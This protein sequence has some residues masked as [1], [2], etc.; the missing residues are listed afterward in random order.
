MRFSFGTRRICQ[1][2]NQGEAEYSCKQQSS[3]LGYHSWWQCSSRKW[4]TNVRWH[5]KLAQLLQWEEW[6]K[7][8]FI[9]RINVQLGFCNVSRQELQ[10]NQRIGWYVSTWLYPW[11]IHEWK[12]ASQTKSEFSKNA[13][14]DSY[15]QR[16]AWRNNFSKIHKTLEGFR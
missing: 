16:S 3:V 8:L 14:K 11:F 10:R 13:W 5:R 7:I 2:F 4:L 6:F 12:A 9:L 1:Y 15:R